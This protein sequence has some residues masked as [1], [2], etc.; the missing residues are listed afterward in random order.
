M[1][2]HL[3]DRFI[4]ALKPDPAKSIWKFDDEDIGFAIRVYA[5]GRRAFFFIWNKGGRQHRKTIGARPAWTTQRARLEARKLRVKIDG[6]DTVAR[7]RC[8]KIADLVAKWLPIVELT[9]RP[10][11]ARNYARLL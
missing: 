5:S 4:D 7:E 3:T 9:R 10:L 11:T 6:G 8:E 1:A 2:D